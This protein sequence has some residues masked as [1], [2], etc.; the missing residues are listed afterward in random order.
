MKKNNK[1]NKMFKKFSE[2]SLKSNQLSSLK[3]GCGC[4]GEDSGGLI[5]PPPRPPKSAVNILEKGF[6]SKV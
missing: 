4:G 1:L 6:F 2:N 3:G 5:P